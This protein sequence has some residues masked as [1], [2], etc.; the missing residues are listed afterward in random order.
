MPM[1]FGKTVLGVRSVVHWYALPWPWSHLVFEWCPQAL[2]ALAA[3][4]VLAAALA[5][6]GAFRWVSLL[7]TGMI[8]L[9]LFTLIHYLPDAFPWLLRPVAGNPHFRTLIIEPVF[10]FFWAFL[11]SAWLGCL[12]P[13]HTLETRRR[14]P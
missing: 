5:I 1:F 4:P 3:L 14:C 8:S 10:V 2:I 13:R 12:S 11:V 7:R 6:S 9:A